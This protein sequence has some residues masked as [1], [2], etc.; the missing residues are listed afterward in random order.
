MAYIYCDACGIGFH[1]NVHSCPECG[2]P[3]SRAF[4]SN[5]NTHHHRP[6]RAHPHQEP[7]REDV[8]SEVREAIYGWHS[9]TVE[10]HEVIVRVAAEPEQR[11]P[12]A[13]PAQR[14]PAVE[15]A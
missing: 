13:E 14:E 1:S 3:A 12:A 7:P 5:G 11:E 15:P 2:R 8:E 9:G 4:E 10:R 6:R